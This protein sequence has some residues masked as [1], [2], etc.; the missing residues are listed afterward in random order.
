MAFVFTECDFIPVFSCFF[1][2]W[3]LFYSCWV[4]HNI[5]LGL[6]RDSERSTVTVKAILKYQFV[7]DLEN[8][9]CNHWTW[10]GELRILKKPINVIMMLATGILWEK[11]LAPKSH[12]F[13]RRFLESLSP[14][15]Q[16][17]A[18]WRLKISKNLM[19]F[20]LVKVDSSFRIQNTFCEMDGG[21]IHLTTGL[22]WF[23][24][25]TKGGLIDGFY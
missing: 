15:S 8:P 19:E 9:G 11:D 6:C 24:G 20:W 25:L 18:W 2:V 5:F 21:E 10:S 17:T 4:S 3:Y 12:P 7:G 22:R 16:K 23:C 1:I 14:H 13:P